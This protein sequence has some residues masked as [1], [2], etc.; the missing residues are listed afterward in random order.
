MERTVIIE[1][2][3]TVFCQVFDD[4][5]LVLTE[6]M[7]S[8]DVEKWDSLTHMQLITGVEKEFGIKFKLREI[9]GWNNVGETIRSIEG[10]LG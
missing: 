1:K 9:L 6:E 5:N 2:L 7:T 10:K 8:D 3:T 4:E